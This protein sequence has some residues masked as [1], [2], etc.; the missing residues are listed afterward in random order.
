[1]INMSKIGR[2]SMPKSTRGCSSHPRREWDQVKPPPAAKTMDGTKT[3]DKR[4]IKRFIL[5]FL[6]VPVLELFSW[7]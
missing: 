4:L 6:P 3:T 7:S 2:G 5:C 1:M